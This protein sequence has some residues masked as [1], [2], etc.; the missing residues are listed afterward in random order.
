MVVLSITQG[1]DTGA[2]IVKDGKILVAVSEERY[3]R[4]KMDRSFPINSI[5]EAMKMVGVSPNEVDHVVIP[6]LRKSRDIMMNLLPKY[7]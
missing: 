2:S 1:H 4:K 5:F 6:E 3:S 7:E